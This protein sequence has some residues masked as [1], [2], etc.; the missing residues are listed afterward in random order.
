MPF[1][2]SRH[3]LVQGQIDEA[4]SI[5][6]LYLSILNSI[7][8]INDFWCFYCL[9]N[10]PLESLGREGYTSIIHLG[11]TRMTL[12][13][14]WRVVCDAFKFNISF[15]ALTCWRIV[16][17]FVK[18][19]ASD[20]YYHDF[21]GGMMARDKSQLHYNVILT[22]CLLGMYDK[23]I[24]ELACLKNIYYGDEFIIF[25]LRNCS[26]RGDVVR[27]LKEFT[28]V[29]AAV[30]IVLQDALEKGDFDALEEWGVICLVERIKIQ[31]DLWER[32]Q[33]VL[34]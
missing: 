10:A 13:M 24:K 31:Q 11:W 1:I 9:P 25:L 5:P 2:D 21:A 28:P 16:Q 12:D 19:S 7:P 29:E 17:G 27:V 23:G 18:H 34:R 15:D 20:I 3:G 32:V 22:A 26:R 33:E 14:L 6:S 4:Q 8:C 30:G